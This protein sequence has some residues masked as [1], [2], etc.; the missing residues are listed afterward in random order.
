M[1]P[2]I[3]LLGLAAAVGVYKLVKKPGASD[4]QVQNLVGAGGIPIKIV[5]PIAS[6][7]TPNQKNSTPGASIQ[8]SKTQAVPHTSSVVQGTVFAPPGSQT[9]GQLAPIIVSPGGSSSVAIGSVADVQRALNTLGFAPKLKD[10]GKLG[11]ATAA[12]IRAFQG[13][14][15]LAVDGNAGAATKAALSTA[16]AHLAS[17]GTGATIEAA[18]AA[19]PTGQLVDSIKMGNRDVQHALNL[20]GA[21]PKLPEDGVMGPTTVAA[22]KS[23][24]LGHRLAADGVAGPKTK[25]ALAMAVAQPVPAYSPLSQTKLGQYDTSAATPKAGKRDPYAPANAP[26][27]V[28][29]PISGTLDVQKALNKLGITPRLAEDGKLSPATTAAIKTFQSNHGLKADGIAGPA[30]RKELFGT[31]AQADS[32]HGEE[33][34]G[35]EFSGILS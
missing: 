1:T 10:D 18:V 8:Q 32:M 15:G 21:S 27:K 4:F 3:P 31:M 9:P 20:I 23:F 7:V 22:I 13:K 17:G 14:N 16:L 6:G 30:T 34:A 33:K 26:P 12:N 28:T 5:T 11:P 19:A 29:A 24:Q 35:G 25:A 2:L